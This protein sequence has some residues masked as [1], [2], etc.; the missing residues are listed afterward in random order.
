MRAHV[1]MKVFYFC[2]APEQSQRDPVTL[3]PPLPVPLCNW[4]VTA[5]MATGNFNSQ[6]GIHKCL[7]TWYE[8]ATGYVN[9]QLGIHKCLKTY[10][11]IAT[12]NFNSQLGIHKCLKTYYEIA[13]GNFNSQLGIQKLLKTYHEMVTGN[14]TPFGELKIYK[15]NGRGEPAGRPHAKVHLLC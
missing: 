8:I 12:G 10:Y 15:L 6:L 14:L 5:S 11:E 7:K 13:T 3:A 1:A 2:C 9:S 4:G